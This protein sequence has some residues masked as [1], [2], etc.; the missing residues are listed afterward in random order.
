MTARPAV[1]DL[2]ADGRWHSGVSLGAALGLSRAAIWK[3][4]RGLRTLGLTVIAERG[5]GYHL[6]Q[7]LNLLDTEAIRSGLAP[8]TRQ[9]LES[10]DLLVVTESTNQCLTLRPAPPAGR[11]LAVVAEYQTGGRGRRG[12]RWLS[13]LGHGI[14][15][16]VSWTFEIAPRDLASLSLVVGVA[17]ASSVAGLGVDGVRLKWPN[18]IMAAGGGKIGGIL[19][20]VAG[21]AGGPLRA[22]IGIGL[23]VR[24]VP[25]IA[26]ALRNEGGDAIAVG[27]DEL[28]GEGFLERN[29]LVATLLNALHLSLLTFALEGRDAILETWR[30]YDYLAGQSVVVTSGKDV[31]RGTARG[32]AD[33]GALLVETGGRIVPV[34]A[35]DV[36]LR[37]PA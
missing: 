6:E 9:V 23:N 14:C 35:G 26:A 20:E 18:D 12:R 29:A 1:L 31:L 25:G 15:L 17:V 10:L 16:S 4:V 7:P 36:T 13:P 33:D 22:V 37:I 19:V 30:Q 32:I 24:P 34:V 21:E 28:Q 27:L 2:L 5:R 8:A 3:Q 11:L